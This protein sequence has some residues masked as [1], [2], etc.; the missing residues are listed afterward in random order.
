MRKKIE[1]VCFL[2]SIFA[3][4]R[5]DFP[6]FN[7]VTIN[8]NHHAWTGKRN[9]H[10]WRLLEATKHLKWL[11]S[12]WLMWIRANYCKFTCIK[13]QLNLA[14]VTATPQLNSYLQ[15]FLGGQS[16]VENGLL[17]CH[18]GVSCITNLFNL[19][20]GSIT[21]DS[22]SRRQ[23][24]CMSSLFVHE[25]VH[26]YDTPGSLILWPSYLYVF[27][28]ITRG[29]CRLTEQWGNAAYWPRVL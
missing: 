10:W 4:A 20:T 28:S 1:I 8:F 14:G 7:K 18:N 24:N 13:A 6:L 26:T 16:F 19:F 22:A 5:T 3:P 12:S 23:S 15:L 2:L 17:E 21:A 25:A 9:C 11:W 29:P 27:S